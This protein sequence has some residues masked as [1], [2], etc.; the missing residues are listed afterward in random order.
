MGP[1]NEDPD[2]KRL[3]IDAMLASKLSSTVNLIQRHE[4]LGHASAPGEAASPSGGGGSANLPHRHAAGAGTEPAAPATP[5]TSAAAAAASSVY[6]QRPRKR[7][8]ADLADEL[9]VVVRLPVWPEV[10]E[11]VAA[12]ARADPVAA[13]AQILKQAA[14]EGAASISSLR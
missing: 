10:L 7:G 13:V 3:R 9:P 2:R 4:R 1:P 8:W 12:A 14:P 5:T 6:R 11:A